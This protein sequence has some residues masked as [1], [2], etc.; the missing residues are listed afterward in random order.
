MV[1]LEDGEEGVEGLD[2]GDE[3]AEDLDEG[4]MGLLLSADWDLFGSEAPGMACARPALG[5]ELRHG[6]VGVERGVDEIPDLYLEA[7]SLVRS[8]RVAGAA[9]FFSEGTRGGL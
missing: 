7:I 1:D 2:D 3:S 8:L 4:V 9:L 5:D 6:V